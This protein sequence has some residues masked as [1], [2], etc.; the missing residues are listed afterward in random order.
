MAINS[1]VDYLKSMG[2]DSSYAARKKLAEENGIQGYSGTASQ[3]TSLLTALQNK[4]NSQANN[5]GVSAPETNS[6]NGVSKN[7]TV[8][9]AENATGFNKS[10]TTNSYQNQLQKLETEKPSAYQTS[11]TVNDYYDRLQE[12]EDNKPGA[13]QGQYE[14]EINSI[15]DSILNN[16]QF[17]Y[18]AEDLANDNLYQLYKDN[19][20]RQG[21]LAMRD[22][23]GSAA[24][25]TGGY[26]STYAAAAGQQ[27][28]D[29]YLAKLNDLA[30]EFSDRAYEKYLNEQADRYNQLGVVT[31][32][33]N[34]DYGRHRDSVG[35]YYS[36]LQ[37]LAGRYDQEYAKDYGQYRDEMNDYYTDR[38]Y[39]AS[40]YDTEYGHDMSE[41]LTDQQLRQWA[42]EFAFQKAQAD[43]AQDNWE[44]EMELA[45]TKAKGGGAGYTG[46]TDTE[47]LANIVGGYAPLAAGLAEQLNTGKISHAEAFEAIMEEIDKGNLTS[48]EAEAAIQAAGIDKTEVA[49]ENMEKNN[50]L[51]LSLSMGR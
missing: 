13:Y 17:T 31:G 4:Q 11:G 36:D 21:D 39:L 20:M 38:N 2:Q 8:G 45:R 50:I 43:Q 51:K 16:K 5:S 19:Y 26:G 47:G 44:A 41:Y 42:E 14:A 1:I 27:A 22:T 23:M 49:R 9:V 34:E 37:Y 12:Q 40:M 46:Y 3:N 30:L 18:T 24:A 6:G 10:E 25:L 29:N 33:D 15:L 28:Y 48:D 7:V 32:L 35:D